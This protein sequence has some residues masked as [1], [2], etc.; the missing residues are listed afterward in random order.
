MPDGNDLSKPL[1]PHA[2]KLGVVHAPW[3]ES[4]MTLLGERASRGGD[5]N[6]SGGSGG[7]D[8]DDS[9]GCFLR[10]YWLNPAD[11][12][13]NRVV[14]RTGEAGVNNGAG[15][16]ILLNAYPYINGHLLVALGEGRGRLHDYDEA[17]RRELWSLVDLAAS[18]CE[19]A[20]EPQGMNIGVNIGKAGGAGVPEHVHVHVMPRWAGDT[21]FS[22]TV[23]GVRVISTAMDSVYAR[24]RAAWQTVRDNPA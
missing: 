11:D 21:N 19:R 2:D 7:A 15:G 23:A 1:G 13:R 16:M 5:P 6:G 22:T 18:L 20:M 14:V 9:G 17:Q 12:E 24:Y 8:H 4:Y 3:R 10:R